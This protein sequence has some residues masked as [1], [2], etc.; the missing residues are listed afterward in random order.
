MPSKAELGVEGRVLST[1]HRTAS[2]NLRLNQIFAMVRTTYVNFF[3]CVC[4]SV[5]CLYTVLVASGT[6]VASSIYGH[7][8]SKWSADKLTTFSQNVIFSL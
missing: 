4:V 8:K 1:L 7:S 5:L 2:R 3:G 6:W